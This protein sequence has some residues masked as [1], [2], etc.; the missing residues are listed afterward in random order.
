MCNNNGHCR[1]FDAGTMC[2]SYRVTRDEEHSTRGRANTLR[3]ALSGQLGTDFANE[4]VREALALC[5]SCKGCKRDCP[6]GVDMAK[7]KI[8]FAYHWQ[9]KHGLTLKDRLVATMPKWAP[10]AARFPFVANLR[11]ALPGAA[12]LSER[13]AGLSAQRALPQWRSD[14][15]LASQAAR[16]AAAD[17]PDVVLLVDTF[18]NYHEPENAHAALRV[19][20]AAGYRVAVARAAPNDARARPAAVLRAHVPRRGPRRRGE[21]RGAPHG[22]GAGAARRRRCDRSSA[23]S[24]RACCRCATNSS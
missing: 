12:R 15:F 10:W 2:P 18:N 17:A 23:S 6:T 9:K 11:D 8:E 5:V 13:I 3:L 22:R 21:A 1:K 16:A 20:Q 4:A 19:L 7:M 24:R 14:T